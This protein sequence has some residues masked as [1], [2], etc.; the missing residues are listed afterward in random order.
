MSADAPIRVNRKE[1]QQEQS[2]GW[3]L[4]LLTLIYSLNFLDR[5]IVTILAAPIKQDLGLSNTQLGLIS[6]L[7]FALF[8]STLGVPIAAIAD[9]YNRVRL[10]GFCCA[11]WS[12]MTALCGAATSFV[13]LFLLRIGVGIGEAGCVPTSHSLISDLFPREKRAQAMA[14]FAI[15]IP[16]GSLGGLVLG[17]FVAEHW[18]WRLAFL[19]AGLPGLL[20]TLLLLFTVQEPPRLPDHEER[21]GSIRSLL[22]NREFLLLCFAAAAASAAGYGL[23]SF[24]GVYLAER[25]DLG[26][27]ALGLRLGLIVG[28]SGVLG[29]LA[30]GALSRRQGAQ[31]DSMV[32]AAVSLVVSASLLPFAL[33]AST[34]LIAFALLFCVSFLNALWYGPVFAAVQSVAS[35]SLRARAS[36]VFT[37]IVN[38]IGLGLGPLAVGLLADAS[39]LTEPVRTN[40]P[41]FSALGAAMAIVG[42]LNIAA[43]VLFFLARRRDPMHG[44]QAKRTYEA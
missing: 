2:A 29:S 37:L 15:G 7:A 14:I 3:A 4:F 34:Q 11:I 33:T 28:L 30:G 17:G 22:R 12:A 43:A 42:G 32:P 21:A 1:R 18:G 13:H 26:L 16:M 25:F 24:I 10:L 27:T 40:V 19:V 9:R 44:P 38:G 23:L 20:A 41:S 8:Y 35:A 5:Q 36:S 6:G 39:A 31:S